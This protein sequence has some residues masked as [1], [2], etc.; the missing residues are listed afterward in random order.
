MPYLN[1]EGRNW[2]VQ[3]VDIKE[4]NSGKCNY[5]DKMWYIDIG[6]YTLWKL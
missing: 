3:T 1:V 4:N 6:G 2:G 5:E